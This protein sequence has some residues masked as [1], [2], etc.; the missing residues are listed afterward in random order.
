MCRLKCQ[1]HLSWIC[2]ECLTKEHKQCD[3]IG[4]IDLPNKDSYNMDELG[5]QI[6]T[7]ID[8]I[9]RTRKDRFS[10]LHTEENNIREK[11]N[12]AKA[13]LC[14]R[15][16]VIAEQLHC[17]ATNL[18]AKQRHHLELE[19]SKCETFENETAI[20]RKLYDTE[21]EHRSEKER[22]IVSERVKDEMK[23]ILCEIEKINVKQSQLQYISTLDPLKLTTFAV[24][25]CANEA[26]KPQTAEQENTPSWNLS[27]KFERKTILKNANE[28]DQK[29]RNESR[30]STS[31]MPLMK[32]FLTFVRVKMPV[33]ERTSKFVT[34]ATL[35]LSQI[36][37]YFC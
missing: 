25:K 21:V 13:S 12:S 17:K 11:I 2:F 35:K 32:R 10:S 3:Y 34:Y 26:A 4:D 16:N 14:L 22:C 36:D 5:E 18:V 7:L 20:L 9:K 23:R 19:L 15:I 6:F 8:V 31:P 30:I 28:N 37:K 29:L 33:F 1:T 24:I 27:N